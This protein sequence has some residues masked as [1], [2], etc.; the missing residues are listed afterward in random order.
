MR[1]HCESCGWTQLYR[2]PQTAHRKAMTHQCSPW[3]DEEIA[4]WTEASRKAQN[5]P[6]KITDP[7]VLHQVAVLLRSASMEET[8]TRLKGTLHE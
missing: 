6:P 4:A 5:V 7:D 3:S 1:V 2:D 8:N